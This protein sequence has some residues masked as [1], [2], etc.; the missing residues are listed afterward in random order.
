MR[1]FR[2]HTIRNDKADVFIILM[3]F[4]G[5]VAQ[6]STSL[7]DFYAD[8]INEDGFIFHIEKTISQLFMAVR[9]YKNADSSDG[10]LTIIEKEV[11]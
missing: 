2:L 11:I 4:N 3:E 8:N 9:E 1:D 10:I 5:R 7:S 6:V